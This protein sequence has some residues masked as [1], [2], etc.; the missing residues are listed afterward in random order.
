MKKLLTLIVSLTLFATFATAQESKGFDT[1]LTV[2]YKSKGVDFGKVTDD[3]GDYT[4]MVE[5]SWDS[6][7]VSALAHNDINP[8]QFNRVDIVGA[9]KLFST[10]ADIEVGNTWVVRNNAG[11]IYFDST[12]WEPFITV[13]KDAVSVTATYDVQAKLVNFEGNVKLPSLKVSKLEFKPSVF[14]GYT[15]VKDALPKALNEVK[16]SNTYYG[17]ALDTKLAWFNVG[18]FVLHDGEASKTTTGWRA[19]MSF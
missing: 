7:R 10:L 17:G 15:D 5:A 16:F 4:V 14:V 13:G 9:Y 1:G 11:E 2:G 12:H 18:L 6:F 8:T 3:N 19:S